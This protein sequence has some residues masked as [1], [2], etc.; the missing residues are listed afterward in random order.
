MAHS[1]SRSD[2]QPRPRSRS[3]SRT[4]SRSRSRIKHGS[5]QH[6]S[7]KQRNRTNMRGIRIRAVA[8]AKNDDT[9]S[10]RTSRKLIIQKPRL[11]K[12]AFDAARK[13]AM[14]KSSKSKI[15][16]P[17]KLTAC[18]NEGEPQYKTARCIRQRWC[19]QAVNV[20]NLYGV[21]R[22]DKADY[23][24]IVNKDITGTIF[25]GGPVECP[26]FCGLKTTKEGALPD[27]SEYC[28]S[29]NAKCHAQARGRNRKVSDYT[30]Y[31]TGSRAHL[32]I[33][34]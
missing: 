9:I 30:P 13:R 18:K 21:K 24:K 19:E 22:R 23:K 17:K 8:K 2:P 25:P 1:R 7:K 20:K 4:R 27:G 5:Y 33:P 26:Q 32:Y 10:K 14:S 15:R 29:I 28:R 12:K 6:T 31:Y 11:R 16:C 3:R 34:Q